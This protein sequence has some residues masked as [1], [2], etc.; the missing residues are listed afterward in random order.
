MGYV[1]T[2]PW[3]RGGT[4]LSGSGS[5]FQLTTPS[6]R[7]AS[8]AG[9]SY[10]MPKTTAAKQS[11]RLPFPQKIDISDQA[12]RAIA[13]GA[14]V[15]GRVLET[16][17]SVLN[18]LTGGGA[19]PGEKGAIDHLLGVPVLG[20][21]FR[22]LGSA[23]QWSGETANRV[24]NAS[25]VRLLADHA[26]LPD[27]TPV[28]RFLGNP[29]TAPFL[30]L[31]DEL[32][33]GDLR[34]DAAERGIMP[35]DIEGVRLG[36]KSEWDFGDRPFSKNI[37]AQLAFSV[38]FDPTNILFF[39]GFGT[40]IKVASWAGRT[41]G[42]STQL[43][44]MSSAAGRLPQLQQAG[45]KLSRAADAAASSRALLAGNHA[46]A[47]LK[48]YGRAIDTLTRRVPIVG[49][50][51]AAYGRY[52]L[53]PRGYRSTKGIAGR[54]I[55]ADV[56]LIAAEH[57]L[58]AA[59]QA[60]LP[61]A[62][63]FISGLRE[64]ANDINNDRPLSENA[65]WNFVAAFHFPVRA[66]ARDARAGL[67]R[68]SEAV[69]GNDFRVQFA[70]ELTPVRRPG[71]GRKLTGTDLDV[72]ASIK[73]LE[74]KL[75]GADRLNELIDFVADKY[76]MESMSPATLAAYRN[77]DQA[78]HRTSGLHDAVHEVR[79]S[80]LEEGRIKARDLL[81]TF[82]NWYGDMG[83]F[84]GTRVNLEWDAELAIE[85]WNN[86]R[87]IATPIA[88]MFQ[89]GM[90][91][92]V[93]RNEYLTKEN[94]DDLMR[95]VEAMA[96]PDKTVSIQSVRRMLL[97]VPQLVTR[98]SPDKTWWK[99]LGLPSAPD[100]IKV[101]DLRR[102]L[103]VM[104][105]QLPSDR[106]LFAD[107]T[108]YER[109]APELPED[110]KG[111]IDANGVKQPR[112]LPGE[113]TIAVSRMRPYIWRNPTN[114]EE[115]LFLRGKPVIQQAEVNA[116]RVLRDSG[117]RVDTV[118][119]QVGGWQGLLEPSVQVHMYAG[120]NVDELHLAGALLAKAWDQESSAVWI[121]GRTRMAEAGVQPNGYVVQ[122]TGVS[123]EQMHE[124]VRQTRALF[125][126][127]NEGFSINDT[128]GTIT[129]LFPD[130]YGGVSKETLA[131]LKHIQTAIGRPARM[132]P[133]RR[134][135]IKFINTKK[136][137]SDDADRIV[138]R[139]R[140]DRRVQAFSAAVRGGAFG[141]AGRVRG[142]ARAGGRGG[143]GVRGRVRGHGSSPLEGSV[144]RLDDR[145]S[146]A[147]LLA[148]LRSAQVV[149]RNAIWNR[150]KTYD[151][152]A[153]PMADVE[154]DLV[155]LAD[156]GYDVSDVRKRLDTFTET[157]NVNFWRDAL[158][159]LLFARN[160][161]D[162][163]TKLWQKYADL[164]PITKRQIPVFRRELDELQRQGYDT[165][166]VRMYLDDFE[167]ATRKT[168]EWEDA[169][170][171]VTKALDAI[172]EKP[173]VDPFPAELDGLQ[174]QEELLGY[175]RQTI[176]DT[177][178][179]LGYT[180]IE[181]VMP[182][183]GVIR[184]VIG[185]EETPRLVDE[186]R[187]TLGPD[188]K[189]L[190][191]REVDYEVANEK[192][193][194]IINARRDLM[195]GFQPGDEIGQE[196]FN[197]V[198]DM[199]PVVRPVKLHPSLD[200]VSPDDKA[201][202]AEWERWLR[203]Q[204]LTYTLKRSPK[205][206]TMLRDDDGLMAA[207]LK[208][209]TLMGHLLFDYGPLSKLTS[210]IQWLGR[211][212]RNH[213]MGRAAR[214]ALYN[215]LL[216]HHAT[217]D[218]VDRFIDEMKRKAGDHS[219]KLPLGPR[220]HLFRGPQ[221]LFPS[222]INSIAAGR[223]ARGGEHLPPGSGIFKQKTIE[224]IGPDNFFRV[225]DRAANR[226]VRSVEYRPRNHRAGAPLRA[227]VGAYDFWSGTPMGAGTR[228]VSKFFYPLFRFTVDPRWLFL[229]AL[230][231]DIL[232]MTMD[233]ARATSA[234]G[235]AD[236]IAPSTATVMHGLRRPVD[237]FDDQFLDSSFLWN[238]NLSGHV[239]RSF[240]HRR[241]DSTI[242]VLNEIEQTPFFQ[243]LKQ[244]FGTDD[245]R[246]LAEH[247]DKMLYD[248]DSI[249][250]KK[251]LDDAILEEVAKGTLN[252]QEVLLMRPLLDRLWRRHE[253]L[254]LDI[255]HMYRG[256][257]DRTNIER[258][259]NSYWLYWPIS[260]QIKA[261][262]WLFDLLTNRAFGSQTN[263]GGAAVLN[264]LQEEHERR[265][266]ED[267]EYRANFEELPTA[268]FAAQMLLPVT[269]YDMGVSLNRATRFAGGM[270]GLWEQDDRA[271]NLLTMT[272]ALAVM[273]PVYTAEL[274]ERLGRD[275]ERGKKETEA[276]QFTVPVMPVPV[277][278]TVTPPALP[279]Q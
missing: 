19:D 269:P 58:N 242:E 60:D 250:T 107:I 181:E 128:A 9:V 218:E 206:A 229:N 76:A 155:R 50:P 186:L 89:D 196:L 247:L 140:G 171:Q 246:T 14:Q 184:Y 78:L 170:Y 39:S 200:R 264:R 237:A 109:G 17:F 228:L 57:G 204:G 64:L 23:L 232:G 94:V 131:R 273:G 138:R 36:R 84:E 255:V 21:I 118:Q 127:E 213:E 191:G 198:R 166:A 88:R 97:R 272:S 209:R 4:A 222:D 46:W 226:F 271:S 75:G 217:V 215:E 174:L 62:D 120:A 142:L 51:A 265:L 205:L 192:L 187:S 167:A 270:V 157:G 3:K 10:P 141:R 195:S 244:H 40:P 239:S 32:T 235:K 278:P 262:K 277:V 169:W 65:L 95:A 201:M 1:Y 260:Y 110:P 96:G 133:L 70:K 275:I 193:E 190:P 121:T 149:D 188:G 20:D 34:R 37:A 102:R 126:G 91:I 202:L 125:G 130:E 114:Y 81:D 254:Y 13:F 159:E 93:G 44:R 180:E 35:E 258:I 163:A 175:G 67:R 55:A 42:V 267:D 238:R 179:R 221:A 176:E 16:P 153:L 100:R 28:V 172:P 135:Y 151:P 30:R 106:E 29:I 245:K 5:A 203:A 214:Q 124:A 253:D 71:L 47:T 225:L 33:I 216:P 257:A 212:V 119:Q 111:T 53:D 73:A 80:M 173:P 25:S 185:E 82:K 123:K 26:D 18:T 161:Q 259:L 8:T 150:W 252:A 224:A 194:G 129:F 134:G 31:P 85:A 63:G 98:E 154:A 43:A 145:D 279:A 56:G 99:S 117:F 256:T 24:I 207:A 68:E 92:V 48:G 115:V 243:E 199:A 223:A 261:T 103:V 168:Q 177:A 208:Q 240:D 144:L 27:D 54:L 276:E 230:E 147:K 136:A 52:V 165:D 15:P 87:A 211:P 72:P 183:R 108:D 83:G 146:A 182:T 160:A 12:V 22:G 266:V 268:W 241:P 79:N 105:R 178:Q 137:G 113:A 156:N 112:H 236:K 49:R 189:P 69:F 249:G 101:R 274:L 143:R 148:E 197:R 220:I 122:I 233:G 2:P 77:A 158:K 164:E 139:H 263:L 248:W 104:K 90:D 74:D 234:F 11:S 227:L 86:Y 38:L 7:S 219:W 132:E 116:G 61:V 66:V 152:D 59:D 210:F 231:A 162:A 251:T 6:V 45:L 41:T